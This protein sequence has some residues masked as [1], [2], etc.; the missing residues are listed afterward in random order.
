MR[1]NTR[2]TKTNKTR[3]QGFTLIEVMVALL[4][5]AVSISALLNQVITIVDSTARLRD[6]AIAN[7]VALNQLELLYIANANPAS[8]TYN[9]L[10]D[11]ELSGKEEMAG[12]TWFWQIKPLKGT[13]EG[14]VP[15]QVTVTQTQE[16]GSPVVTLTGVIDSFH[17]P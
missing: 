13:A 16:D 11:D 12:R 17:Q 14:S 1:N 4:V 3:N 2:P 15:L 10:I 5:V 8:R 7:W 9:Q 6:K